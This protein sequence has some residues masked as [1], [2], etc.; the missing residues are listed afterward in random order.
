M[1][2]FLVQ[3][4]QAAVTATQAPAVEPLQLCY[5]LT[6]PPPSVTM[7]FWF[8]GVDGTAVEYAFDAY[9][10]WLQVSQGV[11]CAAIRASADQ[12]IIGNIAQANH[13]IETD[14]VG[15]TI[16]WLSVDCLT[17]F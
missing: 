7:S 12:S 2:S 6:A 5:Q 3:A 10:I 16:G 1:I 13:F 8:L 9:N 4:L 14:I 11:W 17:S 15:L